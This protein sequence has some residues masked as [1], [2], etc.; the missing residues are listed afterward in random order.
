M[1]QWLFALV[2]LAYRGV[3]QREAL[4]QKPHLLKKLFVHSSTFPPQPA[5]KLCPLGDFSFMWSTLKEE[6]RQTATSALSVDTRGPLAFV[7]WK[8]W[9]V[10]M[11]R[12][13]PEAEG[14]LSCLKDWP[15][16]E[17]VI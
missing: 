9:G 15:L 1:D 8:C 5:A 11:R 2:L 6:K 10:L 13:F 14:G 3:K 12:V 17:V 7:L 16:W 4:F